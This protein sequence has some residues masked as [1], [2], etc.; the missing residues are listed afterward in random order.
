MKHHNICLTIHSLIAHGGEERMCVLLANELSKRGYHIIV[1]TL[2]QFLSEK[3]NYKLNA[4]IKTYTLVRNRIERKFFSYK[5]LEELPLLRYKHILKKLNISLVIDVD[6]HQSL[7]TTKVTKGTNIKVVSW[8]HFNYER[9]KKRWSYQVMLDCFRSGKVDKL[10][11]LTKS[12]IRPYIEEEKF[13]P[14]FIH[15]IYNPSPIEVDNYTEHNSKKVLAVG[16]YNEQKGFDLL[17]KCWS[18][19]EMRCN[20][21]ELEIVGDGP[22]RDSLQELIEKL[23][24]NKVKLSHYTDNIVDKYKGASIYVLSSRYEG[25][26]LV[27]LE[28]M[29][30]SLPIV[31][32]D[33]KTGPNE[34]IKDGYNGFLVESEN[35]NMLAEKLLMLIKD[36]KLCKQ[37]SRNAFEES[38]KYKINNFINQWVKLIESL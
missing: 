13:S 34:I 14:S 27:L 21:W 8:D 6:I 35:I 16:R 11:L 29:A 22:M 9:F 5:L 19:V 36:D 24:L 28:T 18:L 15:Q 1:L 10:V 20:D 7:V 4:N 2:H 3:S 23:H 26:P 12:D 38:K 37:M 30:L 33:C 17:L 25:F 32:F 31:A